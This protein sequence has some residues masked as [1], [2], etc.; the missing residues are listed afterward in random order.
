[1]VVGISNETTKSKWK[2]YGLEIEGKQQKNNNNK[3][4]TTLLHTY[5]LAHT[6]IGL[7]GKL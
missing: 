6:F 4:Q 1:M 5:T 7:D 2:F 3:N